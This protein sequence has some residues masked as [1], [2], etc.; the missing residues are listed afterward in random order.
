LVQRG[1]RALGEL[2]QPIT[3]F[4]VPVWFVLVGFRRNIAA[5][6]RPAV[7]AFGVALSMAAVPGKLSCA[8][9]VWTAASGS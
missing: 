8:I 9:G 6:A 5:L 7:L 3:S 1:E 2:L 4:F